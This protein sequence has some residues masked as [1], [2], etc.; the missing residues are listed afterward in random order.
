MP[1]SLLPFIS[2]PPKNN[3]IN[4]PVFPSRIFCLLPGTATP[5][6]CAYRHDHF[7]RK[8]P[9]GTGTP[10]YKARSVELLKARYY[11]VWT[12][13]SKARNEVRKVRTSGVDVTYR[14]ACGLLLL[15]PLLLLPSTSASP[16]STF[17]FWGFFYYVILKCCQRHR[18]PSHSHFG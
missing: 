18:M 12:R 14:C 5:T 11:S 4:N 15:L 13:L 9:P 7:K 2:T 6:A 3:N 8:F 10:A 16:S 1:L 17:W